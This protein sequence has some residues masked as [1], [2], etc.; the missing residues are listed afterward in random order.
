MLEIAFSALIWVVTIGLI[1]L[2]ASIIIGNL[3][4]C[5]WDVR[6]QYAEQQQREA[7]KKCEELR[8]ELRKKDIKGE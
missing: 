1:L 3:F 4:G 2:F 6:V 7:E 5:F 8:E